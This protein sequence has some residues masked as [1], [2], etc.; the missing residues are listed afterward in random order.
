MSPRFTPQ[1]LPNPGQRI[2]LIDMPM[3]PNPILPGSTGTV[4]WVASAPGGTVQI[5]VQWDNGRS[6][7]LSVPP[8]RFEVLP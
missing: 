7:A 1:L 4:Q 5:V 2:R 3:D 6:L 8:D